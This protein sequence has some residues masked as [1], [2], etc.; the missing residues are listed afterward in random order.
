MPLPPPSLRR[1]PSSEAMCERHWKQLMQVTMKSFEKGPSFCLDDVLQLNLHEHVD[2][3]SDIVETANKELKIEQKLRKIEGAWDSLRL[4]FVPYG[5]GEVSTLA[6]PDEVLDTLDD[7]QLQLQTMAGMGRC[8][9]CTPGRARAGPALLPLPP[10]PTPLMRANVAARF[11]DFF[12]GRVVSWTGT[13]STVETVLKQWLSVQRLW[14]SLEAIFLTSADIRSQL[15]EDTKRFETLDQEFKDLMGQAVDTPSVVEACTE[16]GREE[17]L[18][19]LHRG[20]E[21]CQRSL[22]EYLDTKKAAFPRFYFVSNVALLDILSHGNNPPRIMPHLGDC[23]ELQDLTFEAQTERCVRGCCSIHPPSA[24]SA[25]THTAPQ[26]RRG[27]PPPP[28][29]GHRHGGQGRRG[30][31]PARALPHPGRG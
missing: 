20:L 11:V 16:A 31:W 17:V 6:A 13:L 26:R 22:N 27:P 18:R 28:Q 4:E 21:E 25:L 2:A 10:P 7:H 12:R 3:V 23:F 8:E 15:P 24:R 5:D 30:A 1:C 14:A 19:N 9:A 29:R